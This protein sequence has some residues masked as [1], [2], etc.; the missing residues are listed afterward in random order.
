MITIVR[1]ACRLTHAAFASL[2]GDAVRAEGIRV[3]DRLREN[4]M[5]RPG[6]L[7]SNREFGVQRGHKSG[8]R[9]G[10]ESQTPSEKR[11]NGW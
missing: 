3:A 10:T 7:H 9:A 2:G 4:Y 11:T 6:L 1:E 8:H 5:Y